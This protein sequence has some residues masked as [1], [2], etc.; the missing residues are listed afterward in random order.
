MKSVC[1][2]I[3]DV[4][5]QQ[6]QYNKVLSS[7]VSEPASSGHPVLSGSGKGPKLTVQGKIVTQFRNPNQW[8]KE[9]FLDS[10]MVTM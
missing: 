3:I 7:N 5:I 8:G 4:E 1:V 6:G 10:V 2:G 9:T